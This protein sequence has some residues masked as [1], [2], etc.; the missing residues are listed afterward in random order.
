[1]VAIVRRCIRHSQRTIADATKLHQLRTELLEESKLDLN[2]LILIVGSCIIATL[3]LLSNSVAV[4]IGAMI[5]APL[6]L[7]IRGLAFGALEG[8]I[9]LFRRGLT[10]VAVGTVLAVILSWILGSLAGFSTFGSEILARSKPNLLDLGIAISSGSI[11]GYGKVQPKISGSL[12]GT[13][14]AVALMPPL[15][16]IGLGLS[17][18]NGILSLG[19]SLLYLTN[20]LG[21][22]LSCMVTFFLA[23]YAPFS[24][25][26]KALILATILTSILLVPLGLSFIDLVRQSRLEANLKQA[27]L[28]RTMTF[29]RV[30][31]LKIETNWLVIP[32]EV[33]LTVRSSEAVTPKQVTLLEKFIEKSMGQT[34]TL[35]FEVNQ[36]EVVRRE[37]MSSSGQQ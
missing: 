17:H 31:L 23:G 7:P 37:K 24:Q 27:L 15:C 33:R 9:T 14:I 10:S 11:S 35:V 8:D 3:G 5:V 28:N 29:Q 4:I 16:V 12:A 6:M 1:M 26:R 22:M 32:P 34:F 18:A 36:I 13:A 25:A 19:A 21:I 20:L 2:F 30:E